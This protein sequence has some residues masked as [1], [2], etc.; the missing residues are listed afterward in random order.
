MHIYANCGAANDKRL[1][2]FDKITEV[3]GKKITAETT[4]D[5]LKKIFKRRYLLVSE[6]LISLITKIHVPNRKL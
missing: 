2:P 3:E 1:Q 4:T 5:E 6:Y